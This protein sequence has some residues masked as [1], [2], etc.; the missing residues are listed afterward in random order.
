MAIK[1]RFTDPKFA[2]AISAL[3]RLF[4]LSREHQKLSVEAEQK[5]KTKGPLISQIGQDHYPE[6]VKTKLRALCEEMRKV[7]K[8]FYK[9]R[10]SKVRGTTMYALRDFI[11]KR[12][13]SGYYY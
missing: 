12:D 5:Y 3:E 8:Q 7:D 9:A 4:A 10:P 2:T 11:R 1:H 13:G 6:A